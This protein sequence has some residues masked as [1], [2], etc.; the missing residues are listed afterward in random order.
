MKPRENMIIVCGEESKKYIVS[1]N[2]VEPIFVDDAVFV[3]DVFAAV[4]LVV[5]VCV[6][7]ELVAVVL[8]DVVF[9]ELVL[10]RFHGNRSLL[11]SVFLLNWN[12]K[13][14]HRPVPRYRETNR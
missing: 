14:W 10:C 8:A 9:V 3:V 13:D 11:I 7:G 4:A 1:G 2:S 12:I 6:V 5:E